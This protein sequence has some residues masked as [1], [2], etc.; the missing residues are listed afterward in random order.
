MSALHRGREGQNAKRMTI[1][2]ACDHGCSLELRLVW[3]NIIK[4]R[5]KS[6][7]FENTPR[8]SRSRK[9]QSWT[10]VLGQICSFGAF[11]HT[12]EAN[13]TSAA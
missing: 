2:N 7:A 5:L 10:K 13:T 9:L 12:P 4:T 3:G 8:I 1:S 11:A 6:F